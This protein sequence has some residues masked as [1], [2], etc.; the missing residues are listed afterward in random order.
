MNSIEIKHGDYAVSEWSGGTTTQLWIWP[1]GADYASRNF[2]WRVSSASVEAEESEFTHLPG[3]ERC[4]MILDGEVT[5][6]HEGRYEK[7][8]GRF[9]QDNFSGGWHTTSHGRATD[10][11][12]MTSLGEGRVQVIEVAGDLAQV[13]TLKPL[14]DD[15]HEVSE[16]LYV[17]DG[18]ATVT[19]PDGTSENLSRGDTLMVHTDMRRDTQNL[20]FRNLT[21]EPLQIIRAI[22]YHN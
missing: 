12:L 20:E 9:E 18:S 5:L 8:L 14:V 1:E 7:T 6:H 4:L 19:L 17:A 3:I 16:V 13:I 11:N 2:T 21:S 10:F 15:W 22:I